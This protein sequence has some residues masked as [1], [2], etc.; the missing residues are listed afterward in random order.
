VCVPFRIA[1]TQVAMVLLALAMNNYALSPPNF[2]SDASTSLSPSKRE[3]R[4]TVEPCSLHKF[5]QTTSSLR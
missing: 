2:D 3:V 5:I 4:E 1:T